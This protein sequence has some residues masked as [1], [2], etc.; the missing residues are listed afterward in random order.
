VIQE[1]YQLI[2]ITTQDGRTLSGNLAGEDGQ[3][4]TL[5]LIG[6]ET[7]IAKSSILSREKS[8]VSMMPEGLLKQLSSDDVRDLIAYLRTTSQ[9]PLPKP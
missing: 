7:T 3:Q 6:Q 1:G 4:V 5:R 8:A 9:V 2:T